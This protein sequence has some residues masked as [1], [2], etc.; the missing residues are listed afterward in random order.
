MPA[1]LK[2]YLLGDPR[3]HRPCKE[4]RLRQ[5]TVHTR[6]GGTLVFVELS[7]TMFDVRP[8]RPVPSFTRRKRV[9]RMYRQNRASRKILVPMIYNVHVGAEAVVLW[10]QNMNPVQEAAEA[11]QVMA[12]GDENEVVEEVLLDGHDKSDVLASLL[13]ANGAANE[14]K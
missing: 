6:Y 13:E 1:E 4:M 11:L 14:A 3:A 5:D 10:G 8:I 2:E 7:D 9:N 12:V